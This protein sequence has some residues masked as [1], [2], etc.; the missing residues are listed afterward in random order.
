MKY[1]ELEIAG[2]LQDNNDTINELKEKIK[3][4]ESQLSKALA[5]INNI[6]RHE[7]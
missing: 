7:K 1:S 5:N 4:L 3:E 6:K 2:M